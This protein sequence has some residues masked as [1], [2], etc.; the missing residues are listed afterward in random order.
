MGLAPGAHGF[1]W[2]H[3][4]NEGAECLLLNDSSI[5][6]VGKRTSVVSGDQERNQ[7]IFIDAEWTADRRAPVYDSLYHV[8]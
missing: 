6:F 3:R 2:M 7:G 1:G 4:D 5:G 8:R